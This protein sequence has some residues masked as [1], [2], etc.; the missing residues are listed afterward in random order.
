MISKYVDFPP[1]SRTLCIHERG[2]G[3]WRDRPTV[4]S[5]RRE[6]VCFKAKKLI[7]ASTKCVQVLDIWLA[8]LELTLRINSRLRVTRITGEVDSNRRDMTNPLQL[9]FTQ[10]YGMSRGLEDVKVPLERLVIDSFK[11]HYR[12]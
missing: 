3:E 5:D 12:F 1:N 9:H 11:W 2:G 7:P 4:L 10:L 6:T 8:V